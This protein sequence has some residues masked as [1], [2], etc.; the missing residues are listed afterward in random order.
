MVIVIPFWLKS[1]TMIFYFDL[2]VKKSDLHHQS[3]PKF[4]SSQ[5]I[6]RKDQFYGIR[7]N[8]IFLQLKFF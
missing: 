5:G 4:F 1:T 3:V 8:I 2:E 6:F 7:F